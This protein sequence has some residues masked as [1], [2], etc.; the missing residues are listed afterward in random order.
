M[1]LAIIG[2][3][4]VGMSLATGLSA[5]G[6]TV[7]LGTR[8]PDKPEVQRW[9]DSAAEARAVPYR[10][11]VESASTVIMAVPGRLV[12]DVAEDIGPD[13]FEG[14]LVIDTSNP[15]VFDG[16]EVSSAFDEDDSAAEALQRALPGARV[17]KA[18]NQIEAAQM[19]S[20][21]PDEKRPLRIA[22]DDEAA[23]AE[24]AALVESLGWKVRDL[25]PLSKSRPLE[26]GVIDWIG[27]NRA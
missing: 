3:G 24:V 19:T 12:V 14:K 6:H 25:G 1:K 27:S 16:D 21:V 17:V 9:L 5:A 23:R 4:T 22:G 15:V 7:V 10:E 2:G 20:P 26:R 11:A 18:F 8:H 13:A